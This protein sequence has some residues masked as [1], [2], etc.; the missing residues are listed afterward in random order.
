MLIAAVRTEDFTDKETKAL[1]EL[2]AVGLLDA[3][4]AELLEDVY[5]EYEDEFEYK[6]QDITPDQANDRGG[7]RRRRRPSNKRKQQGL[8]PRPNALQ[9]LASRLFFSAGNRD[10]QPA[11]SY[12]SPKRPRYGPPK[13]KPSYGRPRPAY[14]PPKK[15]KRPSYHK[16]KPTYN[17]PKPTYEEPKPSHENPAEQDEY[18]S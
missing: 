2:R 6:D 12:G 8:G 17:K 4:I 10:S 9:V 5:D 3:D 7:P 16:P 13:H 11:A 1:E 18:G 15:K 14:G